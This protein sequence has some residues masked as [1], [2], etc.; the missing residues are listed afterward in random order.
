MTSSFCNFDSDDGR[1]VKGRD[2]AEDQIWISERKITSKAY[3]ADV[4]LLINV[5]RDI[6]YLF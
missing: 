5:A 2:E 6:D 3:D 4:I 1:R